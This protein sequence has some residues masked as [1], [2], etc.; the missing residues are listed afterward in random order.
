MLGSFNHDLQGLQPRKHG[1]VPITVDNWRIND[2][3]G[4]GTDIEVLLQLW[5]GALVCYSLNIPPAFHTRHD[6]YKLQGYN[7]G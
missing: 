2:G 1:P 5:P 3:Y 7:Y 6:S 4:S